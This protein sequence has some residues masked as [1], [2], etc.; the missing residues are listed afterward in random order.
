MI[1]LFLA[2]VFFSFTVTPPVWTNNLEN[3][4]QIAKKEH[5]FILLNFSGSD[6]CIPCIRLHQE[7]FETESFKKQAFT[8]VRLTI[9]PDGGISRLRLFGTIDTSVLT[10]DDINEMTPS[11]FSENF[12]KCCGSITWVNKMQAARPFS[13]R[14]DLH[15]KA[16]KLWFDCAK[17]DWLEAFAAHPRIGDVASLKQKFQNTAAWASGEQSSVE[18]ATTAVLEDLKTLNDAYFAKFG[19]IFIVFATGKSAAEMLSILK[20]RIENDT[21]EEIINAMKEQAKITKVRL[22]KLLA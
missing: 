20:T 16:F 13:D 11:V 12:I 17:S 5:K 4:K 2:V 19:F 15:R 8:H 6:W 7:V 9:F 3:A 18:Q 22:E 14:K 21:V 1:K 10:L